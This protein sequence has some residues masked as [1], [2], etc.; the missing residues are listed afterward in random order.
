MRCWRNIGLALVSG[1]MFFETI[2]SCVMNC[3]AVISTIMTDATT[4]VCH[5]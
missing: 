5:G 3:D 1:D 4:M 2:C